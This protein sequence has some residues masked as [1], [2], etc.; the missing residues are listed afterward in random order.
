MGKMHRG[1]GFGGTGGGHFPYVSVI[2]LVGLVGLVSLL[3]LVSLFGLVSLVGMWYQVGPILGT[4][5]LF[6]LIQKYFEMEILSLMIKKE[7]DDPQVSDGL[8][9]NSNECVD[10]DD[11]KE[12]DDP[13]VFDPKRISIGS[14]DFDNP[15]VYGDTFSPSSSM[16]LLLLIV[17]E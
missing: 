13:Q 15:R 2:G 14:M 9:V 3:G 5:L 4:F 7:F 16:V 10:F 8:K 12:F 1:W 6:D 17:V 11:Q